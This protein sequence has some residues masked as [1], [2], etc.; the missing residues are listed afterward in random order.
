MTVVDAVDNGGFDFDIDGVG[1]DDTVVDGAAVE[2]CFAFTT[3][4]EL[5]FIAT[6]ISVVFPEKDSAGKES[7]FIAD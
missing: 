5:D 2:I 6:I 1:T 4:D 3:G 7:G